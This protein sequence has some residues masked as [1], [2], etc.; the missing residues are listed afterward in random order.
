MVMKTGFPE[1]VLIPIVPVLLVSWQMLS[2][3]PSNAAAVLPEELYA[4]VEIF[5]AIDHNI[6]L[7]DPDKLLD[8]VVEIHL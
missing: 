2:P 7:K 5:V 4:P 1:P 6:T 8:R 3:I